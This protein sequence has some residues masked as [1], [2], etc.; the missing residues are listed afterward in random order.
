VGEVL[1]LGAIITFLVWPWWA[2]LGITVAAFLTARL[3]ID[4]VVPLVAFEAFGSPSD[5][6]RASIHFWLVA[7]VSLVMVI[8]VIVVMLRR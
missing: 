7:P 2:A 8:A 5:A 4:S 6:K 1:V 3:L